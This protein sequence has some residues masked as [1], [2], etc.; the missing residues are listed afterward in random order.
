MKSN[1]DE[2]LKSALMATLDLVPDADVIF[3]PEQLFPFSRKF[4]PLEFSLVVSNPKVAFC[5]RKDL[6]HRLDRRL[7]EAIATPEQ[8]TY[9]ND[10][11]FVACLSPPRTFRGLYEERRYRDY[12]GKR[13]SVLANA[14]GRN[15]TP[16]WRIDKGAGNFKALVVGATNMGNVGDDII[17]GSIGS[18]LREA[19]A[20]CS[21]FYSDFR[22]SRADLADF[23]LVI[24]GGG[25]IVYASQFGQNETDN[26]AN[27]FKIP[28][29]TKELSIACIVLGVG[30]QGRREQFFGDPLVRQFL[31][32]RCWQQPTSSCEIVPPGKC[33]AN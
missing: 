15:S 7:V 1:V 21:V 29:W 13:A 33:S 19:K 14:Q 2:N 9:S 24:V 10:A 26:L 18:W 6:L 17:A 25:G 22:V 3:T 11:F 32:R 12:M 28:L 16:Y 5:A 31:E 20:D 4:Y 23:D 30:V 27:Y 8:I